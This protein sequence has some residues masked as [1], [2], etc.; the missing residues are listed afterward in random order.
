MLHAGERWRVSLRLTQEDFDAFAELSG[1]TNPIHIDPAFA[2]RTRF[3]KTV[4]H[5]MLLFS[6]LAAAVSRRLGPTYRVSTQNLVFPAPTFAGVPLVAHFQVEADAGAD[7]V[8]LR[9]RVETDTGTTTLMGT[10]VLVPHQEPRDLQPET[11]VGE[12]S[13]ATKLGHLT[14]GATA[15]KERTIHPADVAEWCRLVDDADP[16]YRGDT[17]EVPPPLLGGLVSDLLGTRVPGP[18]ANWLKQRYAFEHPVAVGEA[19]T[20]SVEI[21]RLRPEKGLVNLKTT[22]TTGSGVALGGEALV[23]ARDLAP[24]G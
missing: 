6:E 5:G 17:A 24:A 8:T 13:E 12:V 1:D 2:R 18:G 16:R 21:V 11:P 3:G 15:T 7:G 22:C 19:V 9:E 10:A 4:A 20:T 23:L 14:L